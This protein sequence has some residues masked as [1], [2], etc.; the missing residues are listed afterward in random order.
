MAAEEQKGALALNNL[1][2]PQ[3]HGQIMEMTSV[4]IEALGPEAVDLK[5]W[6]EDPDRFELWEGTSGGEEFRAEQSKTLEGIAL[7]FGYLSAVA[8]SQSMSIAEVV[9]KHR[10]YAA[11]H[12]EQP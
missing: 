5:Q 10:S 2:M 3:L 7:A 1:P 4:L 11:V 12:G 6:L 8:A 9:D